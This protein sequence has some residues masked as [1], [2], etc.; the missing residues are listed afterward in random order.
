MAM[1]AQIF[2]NMIRHDRVRF[3]QIAFLVFDECHHAVEKHPMAEVKYPN[4]Y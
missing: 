2:L 1:T 3:S 4:I